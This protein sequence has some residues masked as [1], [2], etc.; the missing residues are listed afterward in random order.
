MLPILLIHGSFSAKHTL[1]FFRLFHH[2][3]FRNTHLLDL[4][5]RRRTPCRRIPRS[6]YNTNIKRHHTKNVLY[7][8]CSERVLVTWR[9]RSSIRHYDRR[10]TSLRRQGVVHAHR[11]LRLCRVQSSTSAVR[12]RPSG[13]HRHDRV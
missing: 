4:E 8:M 1:T 7:W 12:S 6:T 5:C 9:C 3:V 10:S 2:S 13:R 11:S